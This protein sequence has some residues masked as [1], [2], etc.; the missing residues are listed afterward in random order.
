MPDSARD[1]TD[2]PDAHQ[3]TGRVSAPVRMQR[4]RGAAHV[5]I[6]PAG[7][8]D[9]YQKPPCRALF[10]RVE[11]GEPPAA[12]M[13]TTSGGMTGG[14]RIDYEV[15]V[16]AGGRATLTTQAAEK[17]YRSLGDDAE[18]AVSLEVGAGG[19]LEWL[20]QENILFNHSRFVRHT[21]VELDPTATLLAVEAVVFGRTAH[22][23][24]VTDCVLHDAWRI[25]VGGKLRWAD[26]L[27][28][29]G[30]T[31]GMLHDPYAFG[32]ALAV[33]TVVV[34]APDCAAR[35]ETA[36]AL[37]EKALKKETKSAL[38]AD[39]VL[40]PQPSPRDT[41]TQ[42]ATLRAG[43]TL[44]NGLLVARFAGRDTAEL[45][46]ALMEYLTVLRAELAG[47]PPRL[48]RVWRI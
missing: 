39:G 13:V 15:K 8:V 31:I 36:R 17:I 30:E 47:L 7:L 42:A 45:R 44:V 29:D 14:D 3:T 1:L 33:A 38:E 9:L 16:L 20:P 25:R 43:V 23:E 40:E 12:V 2:L 22:G 24:S 41:C 37:L 19:Y 21:H 10:P 46:G 6:G 11:K 27:S 4:N 32:G 48:P 34:Y 18:M 28:L 26:G 35:L 5:V